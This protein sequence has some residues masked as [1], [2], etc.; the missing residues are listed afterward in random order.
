MDF[1][2]VD[3]RRI[4]PAPVLL[5]GWDFVSSNKMDK[6]CRERSPPFSRSCLRCWAGDNCLKFPLPVRAA[7]LLNSRWNKNPQFG[8][9]CREY[10]ASEHRRHCI[11]GRF[12]GGCR[13]RNIF[14]AGGLSLLYGVVSRTGGSI[15]RPANFSRISCAQSMSTRGLIRSAGLSF[16]SMSAVSTF[17]KPWNTWVTSFSGWMRPA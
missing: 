16:I 6:L 8:F 14:P 15:P 7:F 4:P 12:E 5:E 2:P 9:P 1:F 13:G 11:I 3:R 17:S 10:R